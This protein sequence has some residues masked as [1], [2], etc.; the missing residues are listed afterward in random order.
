MW[1]TRSTATPGP[2]SW[3]NRASSWLQAVG[4]LLLAVVEE[5][6]HRRR[7][8]LGG[9]RL[10]Q[11]RDELVVVAGEQVVAHLGERVHV[12]GPAAALRA[13]GL[14]HQ[15]ELLELLEVAADARAG[16]AQGGAELGDGLRPVALEEV[17]DGAPGRR[18]GS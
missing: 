17:Q 9:G 2:A 10:Q 16:L 1:A 5:A 6:L 11:L 8:E 4:Q 15:P 18:A 3:R 12:G 14:L 7:A 13:A